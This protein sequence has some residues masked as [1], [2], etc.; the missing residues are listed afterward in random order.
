M[1]SHRLTKL[2]AA[3]TFSWLWSTPEAFLLVS[4][5]SQ[6]FHHPESSKTMRASRSSSSLSMGSENA[7]REMARRIMYHQHR[8]QRENMRYQIIASEQC[9]SLGRRIEDVSS[10]LLANARNFFWSSS[11]EEKLESNMS[12]TQAFSF[13]P[14]IPWQIHLSPNQMGQIP[15]WHGQ[16]RNWRF[17]AT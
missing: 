9:E 15:R 11:S 14:E 13:A 16:H 12:L 7:E 4:S 2:V 3:L 6:D 5:A 8:K 10:V 1:S 17:H